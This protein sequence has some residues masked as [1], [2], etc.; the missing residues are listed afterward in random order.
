VSEARPRL[1]PG[2]IEVDI[3]EPGVEIF[4]DGWAR[5]NRR[6]SPPSPTT[7]RVSMPRTEHAP[8]IVKPGLRLEGEDGVGEDGGG[9]AV[10]RRA[11]GDMAF[12]YPLSAGLLSRTSWTPAFG[13]G[14]RGRWPRPVAHTEVA[15]GGRQPR[16]PETAAQ[17]VTPAS[18]PAERVP[19]VDGSEE[20]GSGRSCPN[21]LRSPGL[22][23]GRAA[24]RRQIE[25]RHSADSSLHCSYEAR[26]QSSCRDLE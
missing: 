2:A 25:G 11:G 9:L 4:L 3:A 24:D 16:D 7:L 21:L 5:A 10:G 12:S 14:R 26:A 6:G 20:P 18:Q 19:E 22:G 13:R 8:N 1:L 23:R 15:G 17:V